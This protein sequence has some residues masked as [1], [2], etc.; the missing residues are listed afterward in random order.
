MPGM[1]REAAGAIAALFVDA[2]EPVASES[3]STGHETA[4]QMISEG[5]FSLVAGTG[6]EPA[7]SGL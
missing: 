3:V 7:T 1:D 2:V 5:P 4:P 6:F